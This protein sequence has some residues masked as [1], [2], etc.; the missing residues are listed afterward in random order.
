MV[1]RHALPQPAVLVD[2]LDR[3]DLREAHRLDEH[4][5]RDGDHRAHRMRGGMD[6]RDRRPVAVTDEDRLFDPERVEEARQQLQRLLVHEARRAWPRRRVGLPVAV[7]RERDDP[8]ACLGGERGRELPPEPDRAEAFVQ[9]HHR[10][11]GGVAREVEHLEA[12]AVQLHVAH[13][14][15]HR[16]GS[17]ERGAEGR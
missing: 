2:V 7:A 15:L 9:Q 1:A 17:H 8:R 13:V 12:T 10:G 3:A 4:V 14:A 11:R 6:E 5:R 16:L